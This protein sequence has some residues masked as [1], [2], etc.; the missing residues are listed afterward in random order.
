MALLDLLGRR[1]TLRIL[2]ELRSETIAFRELQARCDAMS[3]SVLNQR[4]AELR[5][6]GVVESGEEGGYRL[7]PRGRELLKAFKPLEQ[8]AREWR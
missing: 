4:L 1:W 2:W 8:W 6:A 3:A 7:T 5:E